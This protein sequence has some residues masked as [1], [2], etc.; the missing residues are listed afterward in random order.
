MINPF[1]CQL[2]RVNRANLAG[3]ERIRFE[4]FHFCADFNSEERNDFSRSALDLDDDIY[5]EEQKRKRK[6]MLW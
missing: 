1:D 3:H 2:Q 5:R 4:F 6:F